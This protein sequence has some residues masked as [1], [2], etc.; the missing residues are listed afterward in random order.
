VPAAGRA[1]TIEAV[2]PASYRRFTPRPTARA[3]AVWDRVAAGDMVLSTPTAKALRQRLGGS[4]T[5]GDLDGS[6]RLRVGAF[7]SL[8][9]GVD[10]VVNLR[11]GRQL[12]MA[13]GNGLLVSARSADPR[14]L[15]ARLERRAG[16]GARAQPLTSVPERTVAGADTAGSGGGAT[17]GDWTAMLTGGSVAQAVGSFSYHYTEDGTVQPDPAW[18]QANIRTED[19]PIL[20]PVTG[21]RVML[22]QLRAALR[23]VV[24]DG[25]AS[26]IDA[27]DFGGCY[28]PRFIDRDPSHGL[29][30]H[31]WGIAVDLNVST[32]QR[33]TSG[34]MDPRVVAIF[35][36]WGFAWGGDWGYTDPMHFELAALVRPR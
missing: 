36:K 17:G 28:A 9:P 33:G 25:L 4:M 18:V 19:M 7:A 32:N 11:R 8:P 21:H 13:P 30:L 15:A 29:S 16:K 2:D 6:A 12:G 27:S 5:L 14:G 1:I 24:A 26:S 20:G 31:T 34:R 35:K 22:P 3:A 23:E 10:A